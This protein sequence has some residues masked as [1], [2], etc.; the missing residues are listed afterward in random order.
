MFGMTSICVFLRIHTGILCVKIMKI[1]VSEIL[2]VWS[3]SVALAAKE[4]T[5]D[6]SGDQRMNLKYHRTVSAKLQ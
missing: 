1:F 6:R 2:P 4:T 5:A 3:A